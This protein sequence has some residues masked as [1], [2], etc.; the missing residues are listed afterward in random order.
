MG[1]P[2]CRIFDGFY[3]KSWENPKTWDNRGIN[4]EQHEK[5]MGKNWENHENMGT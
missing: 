4:L 2:S 3:V 5:N 1:G